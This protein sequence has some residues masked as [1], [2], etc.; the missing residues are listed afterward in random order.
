MIFEYRA[1]KDGKVVKSKIESDGEKA[2]IDYLKSNDLIPIEIKQMST[3]SS[4]N[5]DF[6]DRVGFTDLVNFT[7]Q[8][9]IMLN[10]GLTLVDCFEILKKQTTK[11]SLYKV[12][13]EIDNNLRAGKSFSSSLTKYPHIFP[14]LY[15]ALV[16]SGEASGKLSDILLKL[17]DNLEKQRE[18]QGKTKGALIYPL[19]ILIAMGIVMFVMITFVIPKLLDLYKDFNVDL[20]FTT[21]IL[22]NVSDFSRNFWPLIIAAVVGVTVLFRQ[23]AKT[24]VGKLIIDKYSLR[25]PIFS[26]IIKT[27]ALVDSTRTLS[28]MINSGVSIL[29]GLNI[30]IDTTNNMVYQN[31][32]KSILKQVEKGISLGTAMQNEEIF[33]TILIQMVMVGEQ[34]GHLD[35]TLARISK[36]FEMESELAMKTI[37]TLIEPFILVVL[38]AGVG[39][40]VISVITPIYSL[41]SSFK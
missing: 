23:Y 18:F 6:F 30:I 35:E 5:F 40:L 21:Q 37:T 34:T 36:Y 39:F 2:V 19:V 4:S 12:I 31:A 10:A 32:Y 14:K 1:I 13:E 38:G 7:R 33:P 15:I 25:L 26:S 9:A 16:R 17:S 41:T 22:I 8:L 27:S 3:N 11:K 24:S 29:D 20:P 28:I